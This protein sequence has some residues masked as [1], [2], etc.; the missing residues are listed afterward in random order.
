MLLEYSL[1]LEWWHTPVIPALRRLRQEDH[2]F[3]ASQSYMV[4]GIPS[5]NTLHNN[6]TVECML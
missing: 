3:E 2:E 5:Q 4:G 6:N 1:D